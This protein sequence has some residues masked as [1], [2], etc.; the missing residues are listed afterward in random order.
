MI[1]KE[2]CVLVADNSG[3]KLA[4]CIS[5]INKA[6]NASICS[7]VLITIKKFN[8]GKKKVKKKLIYLGIIVTT[9]F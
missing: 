3:A 7:L 6:K 1:Q 8:K 2:S 9:K 4:K 5:I